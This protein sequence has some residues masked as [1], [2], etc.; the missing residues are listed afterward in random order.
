MIGI[1]LQNLFPYDGAILIGAVLGFFFLFLPCKKN[2]AMVYRH[3]NKTD[4]VSNLAAKQKKAFFSVTA[5]EKTLTAQDLLSARTETNKKYAFFTNLTSGFP[6]FGMLG[7]VIS[8]I[9]MVNESGFEVSNAFFGALTSTFWGIICAI[10]YK[11]LDSTISYMIDDNEK[12]L[13]YLFNPDKG[14]QTS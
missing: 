3:F 2:A 10:V 6:L 7:T 5:E 4:S 8:L 13:E 12:H 11:A 1:I 14:K 9:R